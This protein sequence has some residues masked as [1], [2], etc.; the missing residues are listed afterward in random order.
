MKTKCMIVDDEPL[1]IE[2]LSA[3]LEKFSELEV[4]ATCSDTFEALE[5]LRKKNI[6]LMF[7]D[8]QMPEVT[9]LSFLRALK[10]PPKV[11]LT[12]AYREHALEAFEL[13]VVDYLLKPISYERLL[14]AV[15]K[16]FSL[17][18]GNMQVV[19]ESKAENDFIYVKADRKTQKIFLDDIVYIEG[20]KDYVN[21]IT[22]QKNL[23]ARLNMTEMEEKLPGDR[24]LRIN[25]SY[26]VS[27]GKITAFTNS[28]IEIGNE[29]LPIGRSYRNEVIRTLRK[30]I[31]T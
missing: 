15:D 24:F 11:I 8:I 22:L 6:D 3:L 2:A 26:I 31:E 25:R 7:L 16:F 18:S 19:Q 20:L 29:E 5:T 12:T 4:T 9:G 17:Y 13:D 27:I 30:G 28:D 23:V 21:I 10:N 1:A 14:R